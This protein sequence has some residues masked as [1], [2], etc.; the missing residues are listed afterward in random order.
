[1]NEELSKPPELKPMT[2]CDASLDFSPIT[3]WPQGLPAVAVNGL[4]LAG[5]QQSLVFD[6]SIADHDSEKIAELFRSLY[7]DLSFIEASR[8]VEKAKDH[9]NFP[10]ESVLSHL[11]WNT[12]EHFFKVVTAVQKLNSDSQTWCAEKKLNPQDLSILLSLNTEVGFAQADLLIQ[13]IKSLRL[14]KSQGVQALETALEL[15]L[16]GKSFEDLENTKSEWLEHLKTLRYPQ[17]TTSDQIQQQKMTALPWPGTSHAKWT[18]QGDRTGVELKL[19]VS[20]PTDLK[21]YL[22]SLTK[23]QDLLEQENSGTQH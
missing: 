12:S 6:H 15:L 16:M 2:L 22:L 7:F 10:I 3:K 23:V 13:K 17:S 11:G 1:M 14:S 18:R 5:F 19:F 4:V 9:P 20:N 21:K 8:L